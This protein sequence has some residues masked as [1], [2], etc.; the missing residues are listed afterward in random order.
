MTLHQ[1]HGARFFLCFLSCLFFP[2]FPLVSSWRLGNLHAPLVDLGAQLP[3]DLLDL[4]DDDVAALGLKKLE[5]KRWTAAM[6]ELRGDSVGVRRNTCSS[7]VSAG[8]LDARHCDQG[9][10]TTRGG[11][12]GDGGSAH[13]VD[14]GGDN[15]DGSGDHTRR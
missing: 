15:G 13:N 2:P 12:E 14:G 11:D 5:L 9:T 8:A 1:T 4:D 10:A 3:L 7:A 6:E